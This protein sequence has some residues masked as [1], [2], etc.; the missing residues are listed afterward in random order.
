[1]LAGPIIAALFLSPP[2]ASVEPAPVSVV[3]NDLTSMSEDELVAR[4]QEQKNRVDREI[5]RELGSRG[6]QDSYEAL[7]SCTKIVTST[8]PLRYSYE[9]FSNFKDHATIAEKAL[10]FLE[11]AACGSEPKRSSAAAYALSLFDESAAPGL[12]KVLKK[13][14]DSKTRSTALA[15][16]LPEMAASGEKGEF[17]TACDNLVLTYRVHR[18]MGV[19]AFKTFASEGGLGLFEKKLTDKKLSAELRGMMITALEETPGDAALELLAGGLK[20]KDPR[21]LYECM[22]ALSRRGATLHKES[23]QKLSRHKDDAVR[24]EALISMARLSTGDPK[25]VEASIKLA[26]DRDPIER[27][28]AA[29]SLGELRTTAAMDAL[30]GLLGDKAY[31]VRIE[32]LIGVSIARQAL[33]IP[34]L[35]SRLGE[36]AGAEQD[37]VHRELRMLTGLDFGGSAQRWEHWWR[38]EGGAFIVPPLEEAED[39]EIERKERREAN[40]TQSSFYG[41]NISS[42]R[43]CFVL[44]LSGSMN[45]KSKGGKTR[46]QILKSEMDRFLSAYPSGQ[47]FNMVFFGND[48]QRWRSELTLMN[49]KVRETARDHVK[50]LDAPGATAVYDGLLAAFEDPLVDTIYLLTDGGPSGGTIDDID[51]IIMEVERWNSLRHVVIHTVA[52][53]RESSLLKAL[54][55]GSNGDHVVVD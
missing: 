52:V 11:D 35:I 34:A 23:V 19:Q 29:I 40:P 50:G 20:A 48:A 32:A 5:F 13:S 10:D 49:D 24:H 15:P 1:M 47:L 8:W 44:D 39:A 7:V 55:A 53:G 33:S 25:F 42:E 21:V 45:F 51:E 18:H 43:V 28:A 30:H 26:K 46:L 31:T 9:A 3:R 2:L 12:R 4:V 16:L 37:R 6:T 54:S 14:K 17:K 41:L 22:R 36:C 27:G 38:A